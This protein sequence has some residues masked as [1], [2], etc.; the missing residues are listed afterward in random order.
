SSFST[1]RRLRPPAGLPGSAA[2]LS[3]V[4]SPS[5]RPGWSAAD[6]LL[7]TLAGLAAARRQSASGAGVGRLGQA[8]CRGAFSGGGALVQLSRAVPRYWSAARRRAARRGCH[9]EQ[10]HRQPAPDDGDLLSPHTGTIQDP[11]GFA[12]LS[13]RFVRA[14]IAAPASRF[15]SEGWLADR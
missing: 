12:V 10:P 8:R 7:R 14:A 11:D 5:L 1:R 13:V 3:G 15:R 6:L 2:A 4:L 9:D